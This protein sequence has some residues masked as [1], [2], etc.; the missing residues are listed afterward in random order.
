MRP[1]ILPC[2][3]GEG[4][5]RGAMVEGAFHPPLR[6]ERVP[7]PDLTGEEPTRRMVEEETLMNT[8]RRASTR[9]LGI[10]LILFAVP[11]PCPHLFDDN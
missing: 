6:S 7:F 5:H 9:P 1:L 4:D 3:A 10:F 11:V 2:E 8:R